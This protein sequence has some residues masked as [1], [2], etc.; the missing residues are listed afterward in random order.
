MW[1]L[2]NCKLAGVFSKQTCLFTEDGESS[3]THG[4]TSSKI[5]FGDYVSFFYQATQYCSSA[6]RLNIGFKRCSCIQSATAAHVPQ[7]RYR[8]SVT[9]KSSFSRLYFEPHDAAS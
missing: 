3:R 9:S 5:C 6:A 4:C 7:Y 1:R 2:P 8:A